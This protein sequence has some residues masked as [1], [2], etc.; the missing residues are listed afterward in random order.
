MSQELVMRIQMADIIK[1]AVQ[2][3]GSESARIHQFHGFRHQEYCHRYHVLV[4]L[5]E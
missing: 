3:P 5:E 2:E 1:G 4:R